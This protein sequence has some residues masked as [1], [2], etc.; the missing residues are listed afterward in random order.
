MK[1]FKKK[2]DSK[3]SVVDYFK[4]LEWNSM[5]EVLEDDVGAHLGRVA[6]L[7]FCHRLHVD[8]APLFY[9]AHKRIASAGDP[10]DQMDAAH[11]VYKRFIA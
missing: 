11:E 1:F 9:L 5:K 8:E 4:K 7:R 2:D 6:V 3:L 10:F